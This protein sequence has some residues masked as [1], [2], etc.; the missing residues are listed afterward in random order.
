ML[1][2]F[3]C[4]AAERAGELVLLYITVVRGPVLFRRHARR[5]RDHLL[6]FGPERVCQRGRH[7]PHSEE[8][9]DRATFRSARMIMY[10]HHLSKNKIHF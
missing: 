8:V 2:H 5:V 6:P 9:C 1:T 10:S 7:Q 4:K 3:A